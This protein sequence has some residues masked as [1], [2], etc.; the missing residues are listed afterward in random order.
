MKVNL[1]F[2]I[3]QFDGSPLRDESDK[4]VIA[5]NICVNALLTTITNEQSSGEELVKRYRLAEKIYNHNIEGKE[6]NLNV[7]EIGI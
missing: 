1:S 6:V 3:K 2:V 7:D 4:E 5:A